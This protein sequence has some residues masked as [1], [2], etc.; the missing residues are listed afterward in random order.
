MLSTAHMG[1]NYFHVF[2]ENHSMQ[3]QLLQTCVECAAVTQSSI[4]GTSQKAGNLHCEFNSYVQCS[5]MGSCRCKPIYL[6]VCVCV[7]YSG[8]PEYTQ[9]KLDYNVFFS[10]ATSR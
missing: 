2:T 3:S 10:V 9:Q 8:G 4:Q 7:S 5:I 6:Y 1:I